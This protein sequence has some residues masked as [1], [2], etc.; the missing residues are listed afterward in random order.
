MKRLAAEDRFFL[1]QKTRVHHV[2]PTLTYA[3]QMDIYLGGRHIQ[4]LHE[5][6]AVTPGDTFLYLP[7]EKVLVTGDL[8]INPITFALGCYPTGWLRTLERIDAL[9]ASVDRA[10]PRRAAARQDAAPR[11]HRRCS[12]TCIGGAADAKSRGLD[13]DQA[14]A[15]MLPRAARP[16]GRRSPTTTRP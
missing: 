12:R 10:G 13:P 2:F 6:R 15:A 8:L 1:D 5:G 9:D 3:N 16:D 7:D 11:A 14:K 4:L